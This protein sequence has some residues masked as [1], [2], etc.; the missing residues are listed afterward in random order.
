MSWVAAARAMQHVGAME[1][2]RTAVVAALLGNLALAVLK[3]ISA[4]VT[5]S[6]A[7]LAETFHSFADTGNQVLLLVGMWL[8]RQPPDKVHPFGYGKNVYFWAF[9]VAMMLFTLGGAFSLWEGIRHVLHATERQSLAWAYGVL[10]GGAVFESISLTVAVRSLYRTKGQRTLREFWRQTRDP[11]LLTVL[12]ED[13][14]A[15]ASLAVAA[16]GIFIAQRTGD[17]VWDAGA[18]MVIGVILIGMAVF[19]AIENYSLLLGERAAAPVE[20]TIRRLLGEDRDVRSVR[21]LRTMHLGPQAILIVATVAFDRGLTTP[22]IEAAVGRLQQRITEQ[23]G[24]VT[25]ERLVVLEPD[26]SGVRA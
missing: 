8:G 11:T 4:A 13:T 7:M 19:L 20:Q 9:V 14:A 6:A 15:L 17:P 16:A 3:G 12:G 23:L 2:S 5:G 24:D 22:A 10:L 18:S 26:A 1:E 25:D 21:D